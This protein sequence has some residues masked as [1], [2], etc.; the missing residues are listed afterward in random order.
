MADTTFTNAPRTRTLS[1]E[2]RR[3]T[4]ISWARVLMYTLLTAFAIVALIPFFWMISSSLMTLGETI[5][6]QWVPE[7][8]QW[9]NYN[10]AWESA[11]FSK[12]F[13]NS[14]IITLTTIAGL[15]TTSI[16]AAYAFARI[17]FFGRNIIFTLLLLTLMIPDEVTMIPRFL[18]VTGQIFPLPQVGRDDALIS[19]G[20]SWMNTL[21]ALTI[22]FTANAF[23]IFLLRQF[24]AQIPNDLWDACRIDGGGH[25]RFLLQVVLPISRPA[26]LTVTLLTFIAAWNAFLWPLLVT[27][28]EDWRPLVVGLYNFTQEA[29]TQTHLLMAASFITIIPV[30][31]LY[32]VTQKTFTEGIATS[33][34]KG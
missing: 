13:L 26:I 16:L 29:G 8:P 5:N 30:L 1:A 11:K 19:F 21:A 27:T 14:V 2:P 6:R 32:F 15:L 17:N 9:Q 25:L 7:I 23:S 12:Y 3:G 31:I 34:L 10:E 24:F 33:G 22:P 18:T 28:R 4:G 20:G